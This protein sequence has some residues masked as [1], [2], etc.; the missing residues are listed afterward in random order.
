M[1]VKQR[2]AERVLRASLEQQKQE[3]E[4]MEEEKRRRHTAAQMAVSQMSG[5]GGGFSWKEMEQQDELRRRERMELRKLEMSRQNSYPS[6]VIE[7][8][9]EQWALKQNNTKAVD[10]YLHE[11]TCATKP[12]IGPE[13]V[14]FS[15]QFIG[16]LHEHMLIL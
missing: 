10:D 14:C 8:S 2:R 9:V 6:R 3:A 4:E 16:S 7:Q 12:R 11:I 5:V 1:R 15:E 13:E